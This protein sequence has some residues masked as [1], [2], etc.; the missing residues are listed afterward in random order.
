M[1]GLYHTY[2]LLVA[3]HL[4]ISIAERG[5]VGPPHFLSI[6]GTVWLLCTM[7]HLLGAC[8]ILTVSCTHL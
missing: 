4:V 2:Q 7:V 3:L 6:T 8:E 1:M 5:L